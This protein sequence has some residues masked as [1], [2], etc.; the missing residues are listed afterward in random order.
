MKIFE[1]AYHTRI[2]LHKYFHNFSYFIKFNT[3][4]GLERLGKLPQHYPRPRS[5]TL[6]PSPSLPR[7]RSLALAPP[8]LLPHP[9]SLALAPSL[10][11]HRQRHRSLTNALTPSPM[12][13]L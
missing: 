9:R 3:R 5:L 7:P 4:T 6:A 11:L 13:S 8:P 2:C 10:S 12:P 1:G